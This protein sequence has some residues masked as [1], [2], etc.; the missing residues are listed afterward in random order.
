M[1]ESNKL[2]LRRGDYRD[3]EEFYDALFKQIRILIESNNVLSLHENPSL[4]GVYALQFGPN[5]I[6]EDSAYPMWLNGKEIYYVTEF[7]RQQKYLDA[8]ELVEKHI[9]PEDDMWD[10]PDV[11]TPKGGHDA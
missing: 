5:Q 3:Q 7:A 8:K 2:I 10:I 4:K 1:N 9:D 11:K 6:D